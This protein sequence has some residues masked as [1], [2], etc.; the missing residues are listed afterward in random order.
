MKLSVR[1]A[2]KEDCLERQV[3]VQLEDAKRAREEAYEKYVSSRDQ[4]KSEYEAKL[5][6]ELESIRLKT[7]Q[8]I[9]HLQRASRGMYE[10]ENRIYYCQLQLGTDSR[11]AKLSNQAKL[12]AFKVERAQLFQEETAK[13]L[14]QCQMES[15][16]QQKKLEMLTQ[17]FY[18]LQTISEKRAAE[19]QAQNAEHVARLQTYERLEHELDQ[20][21]MQAAEIENQC[22]C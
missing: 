11:T 17:E 10:R 20:V 12:H 6:E 2:H 22:V 3:Q 15:E 9:D 21:T 19:L 14:G 4:Y 18:G 5:R 8:E 7:G 16:K 13:A 1:C